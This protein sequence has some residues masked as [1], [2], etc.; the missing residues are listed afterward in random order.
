[1]AFWKG[2]SHTEKSVA[3]KM[4]WKDRKC[5]HRS[6][7]GSRHEQKVTAIGRQCKCNRSSCLIFMEWHALP[8]SSRL[9]GWTVVVLLTDSSWWSCLWSH[10]WMPVLRFWG[11]DVLWLGCPSPG[12][13]G[14]EGGGGLCPAGC[15]YAETVSMELLCWTL[16][17]HWISMKNHVLALR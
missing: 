6:Y 8:Q 12:D 4:A 13:P 14:A 7:V 16:H 11:L 1:M 5:K 2:I 17:P 9:L 15:L 3:K 10:Q